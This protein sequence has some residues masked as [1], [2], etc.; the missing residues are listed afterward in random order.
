MTYDEMKT[1]RE[2]R[3]AAWEAKSGA[4][5]KMLM[6]YARAR[7]SRDS[8]CL[9]WIGST[10]FTDRSEYFDAVLNLHLGVRDFR[11]VCVLTACFHDLIEQYMGVMEDVKDYERRIK[12]LE[13]PKGWFKSLFSDDKDEIQ[14]WKDRIVERH[15]WMANYRAKHND[16]WEWIDNEMKRLLDELG[17]TPTDWESTLYKSL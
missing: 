14:E 11:K 15:E 9:R 12:E 7:W 13:K 17:E 8:Q 1:A 6:D 4:N 2:E 3:I 5:Y 10:Y 16:K